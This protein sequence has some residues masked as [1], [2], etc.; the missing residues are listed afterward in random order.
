MNLSS[1]IRSIAPEIEYTGVAHFKDLDEVLKSESDRA[2]PANEQAELIISHTAR[3]GPRFV[4]M[5]G[6][7]VDS[8]RSPDVDSI[9]QRG[10]YC[11]QGTVRHSKRF[12][13]DG[14]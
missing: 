2:L 10:G 7:N 6:N 4:E 8:N 11:E 12:L 5:E 9:S 14:N 1:I 3:I 13:D